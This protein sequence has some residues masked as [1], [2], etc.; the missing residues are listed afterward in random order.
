MDAA[1]S[2]FKHAL[3]EVAID[4]L[5]R[6]K[7]IG[8]PKVDPG[9]DHRNQLTIR[10]SARCASWGGQP[11]KNVSKTP[12]VAGQWQRKGD[13][14]DLVITENETAPNIPGGRKIGAVVAIFR[15]QVDT[16]S[17]GAGGT[18]YAGSSR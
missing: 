14:F 12:L 17:S 9:G 6:T 16:L 2:S 4:V 5:K 1:G 18:R 15:G 11:V 13:A 7:N 8:D 10:S 3:F